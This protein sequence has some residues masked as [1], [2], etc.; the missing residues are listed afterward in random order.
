MFEERG[1]GPVPRNCTKGIFDVSGDKD[2]CGFGNSK[3]A[4]VVNHFVSSSREQ[5]SILVWADGLD[6]GGFGN[7]KDK[8]GG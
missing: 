5:G 3:G 4:Q 1:K 7:V 2:I 8:T 6:D